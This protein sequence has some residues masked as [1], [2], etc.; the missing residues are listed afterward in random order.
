[1][2]RTFITESPYGGFPHIFIATAAYQFHPNYTHSLAAAMPMLQQNGIAV[3][4]CHVAEHC[5]VDD[6]RNALVREFMQSK[7]SHLVFIDNDVG[8]GP[9]ELLRLA[10]HDRDMVAGVYPLKEDD[11]GYPVRVES[12][13]DLYA[14]KDGLVEVVGLPTGFMKISRSCLEKMIE[15]HG[16]RKFWGRGQDQDGPPHVILFE[17]TFKDG[18][19]YSGD[20]AFCEKWREMGGKMYVDPE[21]YFTHS[22]TKEW[23]GRLGDY[24]R[25]EFGVTQ[26]KFDSAIESVRGGKM[27]AE[28]VKALIDGWGN[29][30]CAKSNTLIAAFHSA[31]KATSIL[32]TGSGLTTLVIALANP[33]AKVV[34]LESEPVFAAHTSDML[35]KYGIT[36]AEVKYS[37]LVD[38]WYRDAPGGFDLVLLD[39]PNRQKGKRNLA[40]SMLE[41]DNATVIIDDADDPEIMA[42]FNDWADKHRRTVTQLG[43]SDKSTAIS[44]KWSN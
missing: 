43:M 3:T 36:N 12:G 4:L 21:M 33:S 11:E 6:A 1:M 42:G 41:L 13:H 39:G 30:F 5:H 31:K 40:Y 23:S 28:I 37:P 24:W 19:R 18:V 8:F 26:A 9:H 25:K 22:G 20:Y 29:P 14:D 16:D 7:A 35:A 2:S 32:E 34:A 15:A 10:Q 27:N 44:V 17:R 38:G